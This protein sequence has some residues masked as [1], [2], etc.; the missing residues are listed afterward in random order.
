MVSEAGAVDMDAS[1]ANTTILSGQS[2]ATANVTALTDASQN[3]SFNI[4]GKV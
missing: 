1:V 3:A 2:N 4:S